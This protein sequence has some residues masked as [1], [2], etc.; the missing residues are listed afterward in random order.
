[1]REVIYKV[2]KFEELSDEAKEK[3]IDN[4]RGIN[5]EFPDWWEFVYEDAANEGVKILSF[6]IYRGDI[7]VQ[8]MKDVEFDRE[9][10]LKEISE[11]KEEF[12]TLMLEYLD[13]D[14]YER[15]DIIEDYL[16]E[17][18]EEKT[19]EAEE[20]AREYWLDRLIKEEEWLTSDECIAETLIANEYEFYENGEA[21]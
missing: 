19:K 4:N 5:T 11:S 17:Y 21:F 16:T 1:M 13:A 15:E 7:E 2:Y 9:Q 12:G 20:E 14:E 6:D 10:A 18:E 8:L 3:A